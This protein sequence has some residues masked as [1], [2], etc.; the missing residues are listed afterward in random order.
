MSNDVHPVAPV[1][2]VPAQQWQQGR[3]MDLVLPSAIQKPVYLKKNTS[4]RPMNCLLLQGD[5]V[6]V[7]ESELVQSLPVKT[8]SLWSA[9]A[10]S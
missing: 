1:S 4:I 3:G 8:P 7:Q 6:L 10:Q 5:A 2:Q 9:D